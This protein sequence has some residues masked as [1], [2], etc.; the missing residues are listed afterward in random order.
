MGLCISGRGYTLSIGEAGMGH[1]L[2]GLYVRNLV[3]QPALIRS[4]RFTQVEP[5]GVRVIP[6]RLNRQ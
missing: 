6:S 4:I 3:S 5:T 1:L 2:L